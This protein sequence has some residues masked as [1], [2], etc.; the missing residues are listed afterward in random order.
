MRLPRVFWSAAGS[1]R[2]LCRIYRLVCVAIPLLC[3]SP[4]AAQ[5]LLIDEGEIWKYFKGTEEPPSDWNTLGFDDSFWEEGPSGFG[6]DDGDD[7]TILDDM[8]NN[9]M[10]VYIRKIIAFPSAGHYKV[11]Q[12]G[13]N[14]DD[15]FVAYVNGVEIGRSPGFGTPGV[16]PAFNAAAP[17]HEN[18]PGSPPL[19]ITFPA[20]AMATLQ[21]GDNVIAIQGHNATLGSSDFSLIPRLRGYTTIC[22]HTMTCTELSNN[23]VALRWTNITTPHDKLEFRRNGELIAEFTATSRATY[24]DSNPPLGVPLRYEMFAAQRGENCSGPMLTCTITLTSPDP[25]FRRGD[26]DGN[27][28]LQLTDSLYILNGLFRSG[29]PPSCPDAADADDDGTITL[30]DAIY[31]LRHLFQSGPPLP[32]PGSAACGLDPTADALP[33]CVYTGC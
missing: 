24:T 5:E 23:R 32:A 4:L 22:P 10:S 9:Y 26:A 25:I 19:W 20:A 16:P 31:I 13:L 11:L 28:L 2:R 33:Q 8:Q 14:Y 12:I 1:G 21:G 30:T 6:Y 18:T 17:D 7:N 15:G 27:G 3:S 29:P